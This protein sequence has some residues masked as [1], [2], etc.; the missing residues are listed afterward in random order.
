LHTNL[1]D[2]FALATKKPTNEKG[3]KKRVKRF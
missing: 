2:G 1:A 3:K